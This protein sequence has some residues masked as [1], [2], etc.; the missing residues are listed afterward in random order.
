MIE[1]MGVGTDTWSIIIENG[2]LVV[3]GSPYTS[4]ETAVAA[5]DDIVG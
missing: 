4:A 1:V 3:L 5:L 2:L